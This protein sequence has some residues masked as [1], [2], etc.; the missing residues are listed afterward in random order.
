MKQTLLIALSLTLA[1]PAVVWPNGADAPLPETADQAFR[2]QVIGTIF[3]QSYLLTYG[4][5]LGTA[6]ASGRIVAG[7]STAG[8]TSSWA[9]FCI[10]AGSLGWL[11]SS[12]DLKEARGGVVEGG[13]GP[14]DPRQPQAYRL[15]FGGAGPASISTFAARSGIKGPDG[16]PLW[17]AGTE[18]VR[19]RASVPAMGYRFGVWRAI[20]GYDMEVSIAAHHTAAQRVYY[21][22]NGL[23]AG[24]T[25]AL[26]PAK[27]GGVNLPER[28]LMMRSLAYGGNGYLHWPGRRLQ[29]YAG[30]GLFL[31]VNS[32]SSEY[33]GPADL[34]AGHD[35]LPL[36]TLTVG[37]SVQVPVGFRVRLNRGRFLFAEFRQ[38]WN[39]F[40]YDSGQGDR[41]EHDRLTLRALQ[42]QAG[43]GFS[44]R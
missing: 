44:F 41:V 15:L 40:S 27:L 32:V 36:D 28:F 35:K 42:G 26:V 5:V 10:G 23:I 39:H 2:H 8:A 31:L 25:G 12:S 24:P 38:G 14:G 18:G 43:M 29:P 4:F 37:W 11:L 16:G 1:R 19:A 6:I 33:A 17:T 34:V 21:D 30:I 20:T 9:G 22:A 3:T 13:E 7:G